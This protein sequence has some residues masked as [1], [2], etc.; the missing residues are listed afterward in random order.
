MFDFLIP[1]AIFGFVGYFLYKLFELYGMRNERK[2]II[3]RLDANGLVEYVKRMPIGVSSGGSHPVPSEPQKQVPARWALRLGLLIIGFG[4]GLVL[5]S[6]L[7]TDMHFGTKEFVYNPSE[8]FEAMYVACVCICTGVGLLL[9][10]VI[11]T[12]M[13]KKYED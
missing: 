10:F 5:G 4:T 13:A 7:A 11:E 9:S 12:L 2:T 8:Q 1:T 6:F 3:D